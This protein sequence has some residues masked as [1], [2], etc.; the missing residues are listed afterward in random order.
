MSHRTSLSDPRVARSRERLRDA[1]LTLTLERGWDGVSVQDVCARARVGRSTF[2]V[3]FADREDLLL[4]SFRSDHIAPQ[5]ARRAEPL[6]FVQPLVEHVAQQRKLYEALAGTSCEPAVTRRFTNVLAETI[7]RD[8]AQHRPT[9]M[10]RT[11]AV[12]FLTGAYRETLTYWI[13]GRSG[14]SAAE[15]VNLL[16]QLS[17]PAYESHSLVASAARSD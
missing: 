11:A 4:A 2:Y 6:A 5:R 14:A 15:L 10:P 8:L 12:R 13:S 1:M 3:H 17:R 9:S 16:K 7:E